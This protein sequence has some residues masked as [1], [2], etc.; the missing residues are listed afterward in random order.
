MVVLA[1]FVFGV[2]TAQALPSYVTSFNA[3][4]PSAA[5]SALSSCVLCHI[6]PAGGGT[7][8]GYGNAFLASGHNFKTIE[9]QD[10]DGD[11]YTNIAE[12]NAK[13]FPGNAASHPATPTPTP[14]PTPT[15]TPAPTPTPTPAPK[16]TPAPAPQACNYTYSAWGACQSNKMQTRTVTSI[17][18][19]ACTG[20]PLTS[21]ACTS[22]NVP[23][24]TPSPTGIMPLPGA[25]MTFTY[26]AVASPVVSGDPSKAMPIGVGPVANGG[27][28]L[29]V[30]VKVGSFAGTVNVSLSQYIP[31]YS[32]ATV[33]S[34]DSEHGMRP[35][36][37][38]IDVWKADVT[39]MNQHVFGP[40]PVSKLKK[41]LYTLTLTVKPS[42]SSDNEEDESGY[43]RWT[44]HFTI[45]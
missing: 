18:P 31:S 24:I 32:S 39:G 20:K 16:P 9:T 43:Y 38:N 6:N 25:K 3:T 1:V 28:T 26:E 13:T 7:R 41:G 40:I 19:A 14:A 11:G 22:A 4:Y 29:E 15:P 30:F 5:T 44:T 23:R 17:T 35:S 21:Q 36:S 12:I 42:G 2:T 8:N 10:S 33:Y 45:K 34:M 37:G 27:N